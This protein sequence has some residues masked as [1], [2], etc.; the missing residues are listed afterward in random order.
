MLVGYTQNQVQERRIMD[1]I[2]GFTKQAL[3]ETLSKYTELKAKYG[4]RQAENEFATYLA[5]CGMNHN[6]WAQAHN[7]WH[8]R[9][10]ADPTGRAE[11]EFHR[12]LQQLA[13][14]AHFGDVRDM[15]G[16]QQEGITLDQYAQIV[17]AISRQGADANAIVRQFGLRD[18][19]HWQRANDA[20]TAEM[21]KDTTHKLTMQYGQL[22]QKY[23]GPQFQ[24]EMLVQTAGILADAN[25]REVVD[26][27]EVE[28]TEALCVQKLASQNRNER[29]KYAGL[30]ANMADLGNVADKPGAIRTLTPHLL[31]MIERHDENTT[32]DAEKGVRALWDLEVRNGDIPGA[33]GRCRN[34]AQEKLRS[35]QAAFAPIQHQAVPERV[36]LQ[37]SIQDY[38]SLIETMEEY[39]AND[40]RPQAGPP[41]GGGGSGFNP[42]QAPGFGAPSMVGFAPNMPGPSAS[43]GFPKW[44]LAPVLL[45]LVG[46]GIA[47]NMRRTSMASLPAASSPGNAAFS[48]AA[49]SPGTNSPGTNTA[50]TR[51]APPAKA[52]SASAKSK[53]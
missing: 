47:L 48:A 50:G 26:E 18:V 11:A 33:I 53:H 41:I 51:A 34:R 46:G 21:G 13:Q 31:E 27:P 12:L 42:Q 30:Y 32:S 40:W 5:S 49:N 39:A 36:F 19:S 15:S 6:Q 35:L 1:A 23:A 20:W 37:S 8:D 14:K 9:F 43:G 22:Y 3:A 2:Y 17:V 25:K 28:V 7:A 45:V 44:I 4:E 52:P 38:T 16:D 10:R 29:W 24:E